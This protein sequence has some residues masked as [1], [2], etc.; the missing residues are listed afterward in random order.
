MPKLL[1]YLAF[2]GTYTDRRSKGIY[3]FRF[4]P[5]SGG[6]RSLGLQAEVENPSFLATNPR[7]ELLYAVSEVAD[8]EG[9]KTGGVL[10]FAFDQTGKLNLLNKTPSHGAGPC[11]VS[12]DCTNGYALV[13][14]FWSGSIA[15][16]PI[17]QD[18]QLAEPSALIR[19]QGSSVHPLRQNGP[20][21][22]SI[23]TSPNNRFILVADLGLDQILVYR[24]DVT[25]GSLILHKPGITKLHPGAGPRHFA[26]HPGGRFVYVLNEL[27]STVTLFSFDES[28]GTL[29]QLQEVATVPKDFSGASE[30]AELCVDAAGRF[31]YASNR[32]HD[33]ISVFKIDS[34]KGTLAV[35]EQVPSGGKTPRHFTIDPTGSYL[36]AANQDSDRIVIFRIHSRTGRLSAT[37]EFLDVPTPVC[38][39]FVQ[40]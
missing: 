30:A 28:T 32:G 22:H 29:Q 37:G 38:V 12:L 6:F 40:R 33:S 21:A 16:F 3:A 11:Y 24:F 2:V 14:N 23:Q 25:D 35:V 19:H 15:V 26:F 34:Q 10:A 18:G 8:Y 31:L 9:E 5:G 4:N 13:S 17:L 39:R 7:R 27:D 20:R 1:E 36:F